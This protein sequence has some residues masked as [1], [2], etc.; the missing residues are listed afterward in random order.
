MGAI[1]AQHEW[2]IAEA[3]FWMMIFPSQSVLL[4][5]LKPGVIPLRREH[6]VG[7]RLLFVC[8][9]DD[10]KIAFVRYGCVSGTVI[11][12]VWLV[13]SVCHQQR[14]RTKNQEYIYITNNVKAKWVHMK[15]KIYFSLLLICFW[16][17]L[18]WSNKIKTSRQKC[19]KIVD[20]FLL[21]RCCIF[22]EPH[23]IKDEWNQL[24]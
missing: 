4:R 2:W 21:K 18:I 9:C 6:Q 15:I 10:I 23:R 3:T 22:T 19:F 13:I 5:C 1:T 11:M 17:H 14:G 24:L 16:K 8:S 12:W 20:F 7:T